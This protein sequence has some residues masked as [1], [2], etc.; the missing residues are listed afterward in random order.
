M[1]SKHLSQNNW[2]HL[3]QKIVAFVGFLIGHTE[4][5]KLISLLLEISLLLR[6]LL[7]SS[8]NFSKPPII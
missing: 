1:A 5:L 3:S 6:F 4:Q 8:I 7:I 2:L